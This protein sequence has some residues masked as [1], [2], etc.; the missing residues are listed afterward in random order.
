MFFIS[1]KVL[2]SCLENFVPYRNEVLSFQTTH[3]TD[4]NKSCADLVSAALLIAEGVFLDPPFVV[5]ETKFDSYS[6]MM[7]LC[8][9]F[10]NKYRPLIQIGFKC[11]KTIGL[12]YKKFLMEASY[13]TPTLK[14]LYDTM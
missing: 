2:N 3:L 9:N 12:E 5:T 6:F 11:L 8:F 4:L 7:G 10:K 13:L 14:T 1:D